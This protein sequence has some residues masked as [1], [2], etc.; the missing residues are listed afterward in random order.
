M[1]SVQQIETE[2]KPIQNQEQYNQYLQIIDSL[3]NCKESS[4]EESILASLSN[5]VADYKDKS[6][7]I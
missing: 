3:I 5:L 2:L 1:K 4:P 6:L 7:N